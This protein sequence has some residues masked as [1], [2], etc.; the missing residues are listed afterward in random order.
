MKNYIRYIT[1]ILLITF[2]GHIFV[3]ANDVPTV[4]INSLLNDMRLSV[5]DQWDR[6]TLV[7]TV[8]DGRDIF[9]AWYAHELYKLYEK[10]FKTLDLIY[11][12]L[13]LHEDHCPWWY[14][15]NV[16][17]NTG[18]LVLNEKNKPEQVRVSPKD[19]IN[20]LPVTRNWPKII[21]LLEWQRIIDTDLNSI[22]DESFFA[23][24]KWIQWCRDGVSQTSPGWWDTFAEKW[25]LKICTSIIDDLYDWYSSQ[26]EVHLAYDDNRD[27]DIYMNG[28]VEEDRGQFCDLNKKLE[29]ILWTVSCDAEEFPSFSSY[30]PQKIPR[31]KDKDVRTPSEY[32]TNPDEAPEEWWKGHINEQIPTH[33]VPETEKEMEVDGDY[34]LSRSWN[35]VVWPAVD[36][37]TEKNTSRL[38]SKPG[39][40]WLSSLTKSLWNAKSDKVWW[41]QWS[42]Q[43]IQCEVSEIAPEDELV[44]LLKE[45]STLVDLQNEY[46]NELDVDARLRESLGHNDWLSS[47]EYDQIIDGI[48][49]LDKID[50]DANAQIQDMKEKFAACIQE[51]TDEDPESVWLQIKK[52][53]TTTPAIMECLQAVM[54]KEISDPSPLGIY[55]VRFCS[56]PAREHHVANTLPVMCIWSSIDAHKAVVQNMNRGGRMIQHTKTKEFLEFQAFDIQYSLRFAFSLNTNL[57]KPKKTIN[58]SVAKDQLVQ[59]NNDFKRIFFGQYDDADINRYYNDT[60]I[61]HT[62]NQ[63]DATAIDAVES[64]WLRA[65]SA[66]IQTINEMYNNNRFIPKIFDQLENQTTAEQNIHMSET[67]STLED[68]REQMLSNINDLEDMVSSQEKKLSSNWW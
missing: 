55:R 42:L 45:W 54:C 63:V 66:Q 4:D 15:Q 8:V 53:I 27:R 26:I 36:D 9:E 35:P 14:L 38:S 65:N 18:Y 20:V 16:R 19:I 39:L 56:I 37:Q 49:L 67:V 62:K 44:D 51:Y 6:S 7:D 40:S 29:N 43:N 2:F 68:F 10:E 22:T 31:N 1:L 32:E 41:S 3:Y 11:D 47:A 50:G 64:R 30:D 57:K 60:T 33:W 46:I 34:L 12:H 58:E 5:K 61:L 28:V 17:D 23:S 48:N 59:Q 24:C 25:D 52:H 13:T 21:G